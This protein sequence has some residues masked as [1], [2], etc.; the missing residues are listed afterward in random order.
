MRKIRKTAVIE[1]K[2]AFEKPWIKEVLDILYARGDAENT[3]F[4]SFY[5]DNLIM[6]R[7][8]APRQKAQLLTDKWSDDLIPLLKKHRLDLDILYSALDKQRI[9]DAHN[10]GIS[11]NCWTVDDPTAAEQLLSWGRRLHYFQ[12]SGIT[13]ETN[14][15]LFCSA[16]KHDLFSLLCAAPLRLALFL[17]FFD[18]IAFSR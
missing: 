6:L 12:L 14:L 10:N 4:I 16:E 2:G 18:D 13:H 3:V 9:D 17:R 1:L 8:W 11:V 5:A 7:E 15:R